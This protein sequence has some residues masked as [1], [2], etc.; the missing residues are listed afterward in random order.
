VNDNNSIY[1]RDYDPI[2][3]KTDWIVVSYLS[4]LQLLKAGGQY[5]EDWHPE[6]E[7]FDEYLMRFGDEIF[8]QFIKIDESL[9]KEL[10]QICKAG[11]EY[12]ELTDIENSFQR[13]SSPT[14]ES[15]DDLSEILDDLGLLWI[16]WSIF[17]NIKP[18]SKN[19]FKSLED[20]LD[21]ALV[22]LSKEIGKWE[23]MLMFQGAHE[24]PRKKRGIFKKQEAADKRKEIII[25]IY[26]HGRT[27]DRGT[28]FH[29]ACNII[30]RQFEKL[31]GEE[32]PWGK[33]PLDKKEMPTP[34]LDSIKRYLKEAGI[35]DRDFKLERSYW[36]KHM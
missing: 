4:L 33:I 19:P 27:I 28:K 32:K 13:L 3:T 21:L 10:D 12:G 23:V 6:I 18:H 29:R 20:G 34:S 9:E 2:K 8:A 31:R 5:G 7:R 36:I 35:L 1:E 24:L 22:K 15:P 14:Y 11:I 30:R 17:G 25:A 26:E 16:Y